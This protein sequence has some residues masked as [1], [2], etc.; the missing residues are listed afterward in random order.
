MFYT[1]ETITQV[2]ECAGGKIR[3][4]RSFVYTVASAKAD[5]RGHDTTVGFYEA[6]VRYSQ[7]ATVRGGFEAA[8]YEASRQVLDPVLMELFGYQHPPES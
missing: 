8:D 7:P 5:S 4:D 2:C 3:T 1:K 6:W